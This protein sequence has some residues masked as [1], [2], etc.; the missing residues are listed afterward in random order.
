MKTEIC[1]KNYI[2]DKKIHSK[3]VSDG[4]NH[5]QGVHRRKQSGA[6]WCKQ[7][8]LALNKSLI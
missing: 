7:H 8:R 3:T 6:L 2:A 4:N 1:Y 5:K